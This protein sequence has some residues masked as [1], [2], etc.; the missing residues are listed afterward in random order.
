MNDEEFQNEGLER[1]RLIPMADDSSGVR[2]ARLPVIQWTTVIIVILTWLMSAA[3]TY[4]VM[5]TKV[6]YIEDHNREQDARLDL[7]EKRQIEVLSNMVPRNETEQQRQE[8]RNEIERNRE[9][10]GAKIDEV[11]SLIIRTHAA[12]HP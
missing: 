8:L 10:L 7:I 12:V 3:L 2:D 1:E 5:S 4:G 9:E 11:K 6:S